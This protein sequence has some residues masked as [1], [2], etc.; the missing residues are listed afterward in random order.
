MGI[1]TLKEMK[2]SI[3]RCVE[4]Q[5]DNLKEVDAKELGQA[6]DMIKD[7]SEAIY[8]CTITESMEKAEKEQEE[9]PP[10]VRTVNY[11]TPMMP[12]YYPGG[13]GGSG[14]GSSGGGGGSSGGGSSG[15]S[16]GG[17]GGGRSGGS[18]GGSSGGGSGGGSSGG[19]SGGSGGGG[20][21]RYYTPGR[22]PEEYMQYGMMPDEGEYYR[23]WEMAERNPKEGK[24]PVRRRLYMEG[25]EKHRDKPSQLHELEAYVQELSSDIDEMMKD[26]S[27]E[28]K[29]TLRQKM[30]NLISKLA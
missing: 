26:A 30:N 22:M 18:S 21:S 27:P 11:Y 20:S 2:T 23:G 10:E 9:R 15:G 17:G 25:K 3:V 6:I 4:G 24:S 14:G 8:Y 12:M 29:N 13:G 19:S 16:S 5:M 1:E 28:E 7:L